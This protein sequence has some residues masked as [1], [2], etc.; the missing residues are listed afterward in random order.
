MRVAMLL[1]A[2][3]A[4]RERVML[5]R[6][7]IGLA[8]EGVRLAHAVPQSSL[9]REA[10]GLYSSGVGYQERGLPFTLRQ[11]AHDLAA[12]LARAFDVDDPRE[13]DIVHVWADPSAAT[14]VSGQALSN[15]GHGAYSPLDLAFEVARQNHAALVVEIWNARLL[16]RVPA[17]AARAAASRIDVMFSLAD[18]SMLT[19][20]RRRAGTGA[21]PARASENGDS[22]AVCPWGVRLRDEPHK[23]WSVDTMPAIGVLADG[24]APVR[25][26]AVMGGLAKLTEPSMVFVGAEGRTADAVWRLARKLKLLNRLTLVPQMESA[27]EPLLNMDVLVLPGDTGVH[28]SLALDALAG[29]LAVVSG[30]EP[31][32][33]YLN[34]PALVTRVDRPNDAQAWAE[35]LGGGGRMAGGAG[36]DRKAHTVGVLSRSGVG[37]ASAAM[38]TARVDAARAWVKEHRSCSAQVC[39]VLRL[40]DGLMNRARA[41]ADTGA[42]GASASSVA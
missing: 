17:L 8:D 24:V 23:R 1:D 28:R 21:N 10:V 22:I 4:S 30:G 31:L 29:G 9:A 14:R 39:A 36:E 5:S 40:Y 25:L 12:Q 41:T 3:C 2:G 34:D 15:F 32:V 11:R 7:E 38:W 42:T 26:A 20:L 27:R 37:D 33:S 16:A 35:A 13:V 19:G 6:L 18:E